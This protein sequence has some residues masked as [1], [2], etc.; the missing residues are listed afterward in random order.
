MYTLGFRGV[1]CVC[2]RDFLLC[3]QAFCPIRL[4]Q[5]VPWW[6][7]C[8]GLRGIGLAVKQITYRIQQATPAMPYNRLAMSIPQYLLFLPTNPFLAVHSTLW[9]AQAINV[10]AGQVAYETWNILKSQT[11]TIP[12]YASMIKFF[13]NH[14]SSPLN[15]IRGYMK[16]P[17]STEP[18]Q[19]DKTKWISDQ[20]FT[21]QRLA[22]MNPMT[23]QKITLSNSV[24]MHYD[25]LKQLLN[26]TFNF[27]EAVDRVVGGITDETSLRTA[28]EQGKLYV[29]Y[30]PLCND[31]PTMKDITDDDPTRTMWE[32]KSPIAIFA[33]KRVDN[34]ARLTPVAIQ[35]DAKTDAQVFTPQDGDN[36]MLAKLNMQ[37]TDFGCSQI[38]EH[39]DK[40][41]F[42]AEPVCLSIE[43]QLS[44]Q[45]PLYDIMR[46]HCRGIFTANT[47]GGPVLLDEE[48][49]VH[50][51]LAFG[52]QGSHYLTQQAAQYI[53]FNDFDL[54][55]NLKRRG[56][57]D[58]K[59]LP[60]YPYRDDGLVIFDV[61]HKMVTDYINSFYAS[62]DH[63]VKDV[64]VQKFAKEVSK[65]GDGQLR[66][67]PAKF[68]SKASLI[69]TLTSLLWLMTGQHSA[70]NYPLAD[71][72]TYVPNMS[73]KLYDIEGVPNDKFTAA[74]LNNRK[75]SA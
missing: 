41:H 24:G 13:K 5:D 11:M 35:M 8:K 15:L 73:S 64:E 23:I 19:S 70:I 48:Q 43:R 18:F 39:L 1:Y 53:D 51:I 71:Y 27:V 38:V 54:R 66:G 42:T 34:V 31:V 40:V 30:H 63:V 28:I 16:Y 29:L 17:S 6:S 75:T 60:Y 58:T 37:A 44:D 4:P 21:E 69:Q 25:K 47:I 22:G 10:K 52:N 36:W 57:D 74:K 50:K 65:A 3:S 14:V 59:L 67:F 55:N 33:S 2:S 68:S 45:H 46:F 12:E 61:L 7:P 72:A 9:T 56:V 26:P 32:F 49:S 62:D 20:F